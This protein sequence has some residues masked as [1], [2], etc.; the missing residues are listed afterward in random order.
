MLALQGLSAAALARAVPEVAL[1]EARKIVA[2]V[3]RDEPVE[4][5]APGVSR[6]AREAVHAR[7]HVPAL[8]ID[9]VTASGVDPFVKY[10]LRAGDGRLVEAVRIPLER[11]GRFSVCVS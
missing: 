5:P 11:A 2:Q 9:R 3:H 8:E 10:A 1:A 7:G 6:R 4:T